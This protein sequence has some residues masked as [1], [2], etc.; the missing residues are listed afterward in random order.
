VSTPERPESSA[1]TYSPP[2]VAVT[3]AGCVVTSAFLPIEPLHVSVTALIATVTLVIGILL[4]VG[5]LVGSAAAAA[6]GD[7][8]VPPRGTRA[9][10]CP[11]PSR[12]LR[13]RHFRREVVA[14]IVA[15]LIVGGVLVA[16]GAYRIARTDRPPR[17]GIL[18]AG[19][20]TV[21]GRARQDLRPSASGIRVLP[22]AV[23]EITDSRGWTGSATG[24]TVLLWE[25]EASVVTLDRATRVV[26]QRGDTLRFAT[27]PEALAGGMVWTTDDEITVTPIDSPLAGVRRGTRRTLR[28]RFERLERSA[29][30]FMVALMLGDRGSVSPDTYEAVRRSGSAHVLALSG[31]HLGV[32]ALIV[33][34]VLR[35]A[36]PS[37]F[38]LGVTAIILFGYVWIAGWIPSLL[39]AIAMVGVA[40]FASVRSVRLPPGTILARSVLVLYV[41]DPSIAYELGFQYSV[42]ALAGLIWVAPFLVA[43]LHYILPRPLAGYVGV[44]AA[45]LA[46]TTPLSLTLFG[47]VYPAGIVMAGVLSIGV[48]LL[49]WAGLA[50]IAVAPLPLI[51]LIVGRSLEVGVS[52]FSTIAEWGARIPELSRDDASFSGQAATIGAAIIGITGLILLLRRRNR[53]HYERRKASIGESQFH[54]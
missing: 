47:T 23:K 6:D 17:A 38:A 52:F 29:R 32:L 13:R 46:C 39:R 33:S 54:F 37:A 35:R 15:G 31:M 10:R 25:G 4:A 3:A 11:R 14:R 12:R 44:S 40:A 7:S 9:P 19:V 30:G 22:V 43:Q 1:T 2:S 8:A 49:M 26:P 21:T 45:A 24:R 5:A 34:A 48:T 41:V 53:V 50:Y 20:V 27:T 28:G 51:G 16:G 42:C 18:P 36:L